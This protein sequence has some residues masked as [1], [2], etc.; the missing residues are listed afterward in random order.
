M[1]S[2]LCQPVRIHWFLGFLNIV[3]SQVGRWSLMV[4]T[5][6]E[7]GGHDVFRGT[8]FGI[9]LGRLRETMK[10]LTVVDNSADSST[11]WTQKFRVLLLHSLLNATHTLCIWWNF[12]DGLWQ[13]VRHSA[14]PG[15]FHC[16][17]LSLLCY[18]KIWPDARELP[19]ML[20]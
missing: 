13:W 11:S 2:V 6:L 14:N 5:D 16:V 12:S 3:L 7:W 15:V 1:V 4:R 9:W 20:V 18:T 19:H 17:Y 10:S 8:V